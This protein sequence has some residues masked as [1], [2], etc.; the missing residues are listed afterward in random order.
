MCSHDV[1][2]GYRLPNVKFMCASTQSGT[3]DLENTR[4]GIIIKRDNGGIAFL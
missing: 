2:L 1:V 3:K 4:R